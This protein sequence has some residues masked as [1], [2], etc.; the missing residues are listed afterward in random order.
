MIEFSM[1]YSALTLKWSR[2]YSFIKV[3]KNIFLQE[4]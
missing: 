4:N 1:E 3:M 2:K